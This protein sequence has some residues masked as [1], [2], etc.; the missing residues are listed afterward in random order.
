MRT[1]LITV[2]I[3][4]LFS[5][6]KEQLPKNDTNN[7][8]VTESLNSDYLIQFPSYYIGEG[9]NNNVFYKSNPTLDIIVFY[10]WWDIF[11]NNVEDTL[12]YP[13]PENISISPYG[14]ASHFL[15]LENKQ[16]IF[17]NDSTI[18]GIL[19]NSNPSISERI[20]GLLL[21]NESYYFISLT[22]VQYN[23][24]KFDSL[25]MILETIKKK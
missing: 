19:Y 4:C 1:F 21:W 12:Y 20:D 9:F 2:I 22:R 18:I 10:Y 24:T 8:W 7:E 15:N 13:L 17:S 23:E 11:V 3:F 16:L 6:E 14:E 5:C 25:E